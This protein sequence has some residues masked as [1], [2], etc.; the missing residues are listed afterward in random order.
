M[1]AVVG[2]AGG[3]IEVLVSLL[4][5]AKFLKPY[6]QN[7]VIKNYH[8]IPAFNFLFII[9]RI[10]HLNWRTAAVF[11]S[12]TFLYLAFMSYSKKRNSFRP[13]TYG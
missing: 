5:H 3:A 2:Q 4:T 12:A 7:R 8:Y 6:L 1:L 13:P 9:S 10:K 11:T